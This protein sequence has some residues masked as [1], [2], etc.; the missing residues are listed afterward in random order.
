[1]LEYGTVRFFPLRNIIIRPID[2]YAHL[3]CMVYYKHK[4]VS[5]QSVNK[6]KT[7]LL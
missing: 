3:Y 7:H 6:T 2:S 1:M 4:L 5:F